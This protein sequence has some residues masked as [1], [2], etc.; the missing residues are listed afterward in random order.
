MSLTAEVG[1]FYLGDIPLV[2]MLV[3]VVQRESVT[4]GYAP[5][6][7]PNPPMAVLVSLV[8]PYCSFL[9]WPSLCCCDTRSICSTEQNTIQRLLHPIKMFYYLSFLSRLCN[10]IPS[11]SI[12]M[13]AKGGRKWWQVSDKNKMLWFNFC[14]KDSLLP[15]WGFWKG[16]GVPDPVRW[17]PCDSFWVFKGS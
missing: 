12:F 4:L 14:W 17:W 10:W 13:A 2:S 15:L 3:Q 6:F 7:N 8:S 1:L 11:F 5:L 16:S 9:Q